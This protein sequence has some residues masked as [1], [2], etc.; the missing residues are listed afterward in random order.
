MRSVLVL[1]LFLG[2]TWVAQAQTVDEI[3]SNY[4]ANTGG[5]ARWEQLRNVRMSGTVLTQGVEVPVT[6][7]QTSDGKQKVS[8]WFRGEEITQ[9]AFNG[10]QGWNMNFVTQR[11]E[12]M[13]PEAN[14]NMKQQVT[15]FPDAFLN[16]RKKGYLAALEGQEAIQGKPAYKVKLIKSPLKV[17]GQEQEN[18]VYYFFDPDN[19]LLVAMRNT[20]RSEPTRGASVE[21][22]LDNYRTV[23]GLLFPFVSKIS[24][25][26]QPGEAIQIDNIETNVP[27]DPGLFAFPGRR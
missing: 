19:Y 13:S 25:N 3:L 6:I 4:Y 23:N 2:L 10:E 7:L 9:V 21:T 22:L 14:A 1:L 12:P 26:G 11:P 18:V 8:I 24:Y 20:S 17:N 15:D 16:Y 27:V 5:K